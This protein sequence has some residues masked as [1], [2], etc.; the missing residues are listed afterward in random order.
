E[1]CTHRILITMD[2][3]TAKEKIVVEK[4]RSRTINDVSP[5]MLGDVSLFYRFAKA[6]DFNL[7]EAETM[8][9]NHI[10]WRKEMKIDTILTDYKPP[11]VLVKYAPTTFICFDKEG[12]IVRLQDIGRA[13]ANGLWSVATKTDW[14]KFCAQIIEAD[15][16]RVIKRGGNLGKPM[17]AAIDDFENLTYANAI[18]VKN[19]QYLLYLLKLFADHYPEILKTLTVINGKE[20][21][22]TTLVV[23]TWHVKLDVHDHSKEMECRHSTAFHF[24]AHPFRWVIHWPLRANHEHISYGFSDPLLHLLSPPP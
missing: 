1:I 15:M 20:P 9:R 22:V 6:R 11:E 13:D 7:A 12:C 8:L 23:C 4:L 2:K 21:V 14:V 10:S 5:K 16:E 24:S 3:M 17:Y 19:I 18:S